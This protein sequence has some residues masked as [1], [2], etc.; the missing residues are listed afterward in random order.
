MSENVQKNPYDE[1]FRNAIKKVWKEKQEKIHELTKQ[2]EENYWIYD[3]DHGDKTVDEYF[4]AK[5]TLEWCEKEREKLKAEA[6]GLYM[7]MDICMDVVDELME[8]KSV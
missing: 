2:I 1:P 5:G 4:Q 7:A 3:S 8:G 6:A